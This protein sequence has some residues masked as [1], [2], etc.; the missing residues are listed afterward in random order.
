MT[1]VMDSFDP[2][3]SLFRIM[4]TWKLSFYQENIITI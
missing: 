4:V 2:Y 3:N 1:T